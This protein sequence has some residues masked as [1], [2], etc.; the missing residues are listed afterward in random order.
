MKQE[1][2][3]QKILTAILKPPQRKCNPDE[4]PLRFDG[5]KTKTFLRHN[6]NSQTKDKRQIIGS[7]YHTSKKGPNDGGPCLFYVH[8]IC[9]NQLEGQYLMQNI[10]NHDIYL[11]CIEMQY[12]YSKSGYISYGS[13]EKKI[14]ED[15]IDF[16]QSSYNLG[17]FV[18]WGRSFGAASILLASSSLI[19]GKVSDSSYS[20]ITDLLQHYSEEFNLPSEFVPAAEFFI[21]NN[22]NFDPSYSPI[23]SVKIL[24]CPTIFGHSETDEFIPFFHGIEL[25]QNCI[26]PIKYLISFHG[27]HSDIRD[28]EWLELAITFV[29]ERFNIFEKVTSIVKPPEFDFKISSIKDLFNSLDQIIEC[30]FMREYIKKN[31]SRRHKRRSRHNF[32]HAEILKVDNETQTYDLFNLPP[33][34][35]SSH[36]PHPSVVQQQ[37]QHSD[38]LFERLLSTDLETQ[39]S[40]KQNEQ[41]HFDCLEQSSSSGDASDEPL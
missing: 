37:Q 22:T 6:I 27:G 39:N 35:V 16:L 34:N 26:S 24:D 38:D 1:Q 11:F 15:S 13:E 12:C 10:C 25:F 18:I 19:V 36:T 4:I 28:D 14:I 2:I 41:N 8:G 32:Q 3:P 40:A 5:D 7:L 29:L 33:L 31:E 9:S 20:S 30:D 17:P 23:E 21:H